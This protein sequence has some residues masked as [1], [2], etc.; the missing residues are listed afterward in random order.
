MFPLLNICC[1]RYL[2]HSIGHK[3]F[4]LT[5]E[6]CIHCNTLVESDQKLQL[7]IF[8]SRFLTICS[9][10]LTATTAACS[11]SRSIERCL[12]GATLHFP[13]TKTKSAEFSFCERFWFVPVVNVDRP[14]HTSCLQMR[15]QTHEVRFYPSLSLF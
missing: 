9:F 5:M 8:I 13:M 2:S 6:L 12:I 4:M 3:H 10:N 7:F 11:S 14:L 15:Q 1:I